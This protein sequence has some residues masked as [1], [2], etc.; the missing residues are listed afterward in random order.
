MGKETVKR[1]RRNNKKSQEIGAKTNWTK[2]RRGE[3][4]NSKRGENEEG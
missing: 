2:G 4:T 3:T 1:K